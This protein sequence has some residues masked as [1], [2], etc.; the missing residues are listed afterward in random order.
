LTLRYDFIDLNDKEIM[1]GSAEGY[2][3]GINFYAA[4]NVKFQLNYS[5]LNHDRYANGKGKLNVGYDLN[6]V[7][8]KDP[9]KV[10]DP[11]GKAGHDYGQLGIRCEIDF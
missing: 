2:T 4:R 8:T 10:A 7:L 5:Y 11:S 3:A 9:T 6:G 1:G